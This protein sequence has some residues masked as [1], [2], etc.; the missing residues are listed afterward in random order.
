MNWYASLGVITLAK[1]DSAAFYSGLR[2]GFDSRMG[3]YQRHLATKGRNVMLTTSPF[4]VLKWC[5]NIQRLTAITGLHLLDRKLWR[6][7][8]TKGSSIGKKNVYLSTF[9]FSKV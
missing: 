8:V 9:S 7:M 6:T 2:Q 5:S 1:L 3:G 4:Y